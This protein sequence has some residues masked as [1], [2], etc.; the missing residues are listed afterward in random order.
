MDDKSYLQRASSKI[1]KAASVL[2][3]RTIPLPIC[4][5]LAVRTEVKALFP[6]YPSGVFLSAFRGR[7]LKAGSGEAQ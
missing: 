4:A 1:A 6:Q 7:T 2:A 3:H 5:G